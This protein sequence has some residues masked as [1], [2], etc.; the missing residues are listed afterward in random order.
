MP[1]TIS[2]IFMPSL[3]PHWDAK[4]FYWMFCLIPR[5]STVGP[6][7]LFTTPTLIY[8]RCSPQCGKSYRPEDQKSKSIALHSQSLVN[9]VLCLPFGGAAWVSSTW[10]K[11]YKRMLP[12]G[13]PPLSRSCVM[14][15]TGP[16]GNE[17][18]AVSTCQLCHQFLASDSNSLSQTQHSYSSS[19]WLLSRHGS[20]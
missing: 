3:H 13:R 6:L 14:K 20:L 8:V 7:P 11:L 4:R 16:V 1:T 19:G 9:R 10:L 2:L 15:T 12:V 5:L 18:L 17:K